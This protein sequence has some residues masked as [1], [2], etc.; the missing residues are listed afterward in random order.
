[1][2]SYIYERV[3]GIFIMLTLRELTLNWRF[4]TSL[5]YTTRPYLKSKSE[6]QGLERAVGREPNMTEALG[7]VPRTV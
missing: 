2:K 4:K 1:M 5:E 7:L 6:R 3:D